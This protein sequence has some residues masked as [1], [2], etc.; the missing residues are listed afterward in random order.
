MSTSPHTSTLRLRFQELN[1][2]TS[3]DAATLA[4]QGKRAT[5]WRL[6]LSPFGAFLQSYLVQKQWRNGIA[7]L[8]E[9]M[10]AAYAVFVRYAKLWEI[11]YAIGTS[12]PPP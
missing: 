3:R 1:T 9:A 2:E 6:V 12:P 4:A 11:H 5:V 7:G 8:V 10:F